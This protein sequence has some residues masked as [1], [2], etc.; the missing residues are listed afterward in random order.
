MGGFASGAVVMLGRERAGP[1]PLTEVAL[2]GL[3]NTR[4]AMHAGLAA[5]LV[6]LPAVSSPERMQFDSLLPAAGAIKRA[7]TTYPPG[8]QVLRCATHAMP[9]GA[10]TDLATLAQRL[11]GYTA[12]DCVAV[13]TEAALRCASEAVAATEEADCGDLGHIGSQEFLASL[14]VEGRH[15]EAAVGLLGPAVLRGLCPEMPEVRWED[16]GGLEVSQQMPALGCS[17][18][19][20]FPSVNLPLHR[21]CPRF[22]PDIIRSI[23]SNPT[24]H[25][26]SCP[27]PACRRTPRLRCASWS[28]S[29]CATAR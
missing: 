26:L 15:F 5:C 7:H 13:C 24:L 14:R 8:A 25:A 6:E 4:F 10:G 27:L 12:A 17:N 23:S 22:E 19:A 3:C 28:S 20:W 21:F 2:A 11:R 18:E 9:L 16:V 29:R 1:L